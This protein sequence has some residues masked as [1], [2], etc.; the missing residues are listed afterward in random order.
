MAV[1]ADC[2]VPTVLEGLRVASTVWSPAMKPSVIAPRRPR[3]PGSGHEY[4]DV[5]FGIRN[6]EFEISGSGRASF[7]IPNSEFTPC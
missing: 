5:K 1:E 7:R 4:G 2:G 6:S 3:A